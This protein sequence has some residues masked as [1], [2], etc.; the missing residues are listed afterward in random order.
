MTLMRTETEVVI[1]SEKKGAVVSEEDGRTEGRK[2]GM[3]DG[4]TDGRK[5]G[6]TCKA[7]RPYSLQKGEEGG[8]TKGLVKGVEIFQKQIL[9]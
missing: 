4:W 3:T 9:V 1:L 5:E 7:A 8:H 6:V 2:D